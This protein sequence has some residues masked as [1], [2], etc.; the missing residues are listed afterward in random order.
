MNGTRR[1]CL[2]WAAVLAAGFAAIF[3]AHPAPA[4]ASRWL[5]GDLSTHTS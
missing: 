4:Q 3:A 1:R 5:S 2:A